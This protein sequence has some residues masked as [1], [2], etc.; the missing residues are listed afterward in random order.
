MSSLAEID[1][2]LPV[3]P[4]CT[5]PG[6][7]ECFCRG[8][9]L[10]L[11]NTGPADLSRE[12]QLVQILEQQ[13]L[14]AAQLLSSDQSL[15]HG[16]LRQ[17]ALFGVD[18]R[19]RAE[20]HA[21][22]LYKYLAGV[23]PNTLLKRAIVR[24]AAAEA[25]LAGLAPF[26]RLL[27]REGYQRRYRRDLL[28]KIDSLFSHA[29]AQRVRALFAV[30]PLSPAQPFPGLVCQRDP[31]TGRASCVQSLDPFMLQRALKP[32][33][34]LWIGSFFLGVSKQ[35]RQELVQQY[36]R[37]YGSLEQAVQRRFRG[38]EREFVLDLI[39]EGRV[40]WGKLLYFCVKGIG[41]DE[42]GLERILSRLSA[43][44]LQQAREEFARVW[45]AHAPWYERPFRFL[46]ADLDRRIWV[47]SGGDAYFELSCYLVEEAPNTPNNSSQHAR[48]ERLYQHE[49][50]GV[51]LKRLEV[52]SRE[53]RLMDADIARIRAFSEQFQP[54]TSLNPALGLRFESMIRYGELDCEIFRSLKHVIGNLATAGTAGACVAGSTW[55]LTS[56]RFELPVVML[57]VGLISCT[58]RIS[59]KSLFKGRGYHR[60][61]L[62]ADLFFG[63]LDG[64]TLF[65]AYFFRQA[66]FRIGT[67]LLTVLGVK[68]GLL[69][70]SR[71]LQVRK[72]RDWPVGLEQ[73][74][75]G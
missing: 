62:S 2:V 54:D 30:D 44:E 33:S 29:R 47:E 49:R 39:H 4:Q 15:Q 10:G 43:E 55:A 32:S 3:L 58:L 36:E 52:F 25:L 7:R 63:A 11:L 5:S 23:F 26:E 6:S 41:T 69:R 34:E 46:L 68:T 14:E 74:G 37:S 53:G 27:L 51:L 56:Q 8:V 57:S 61:E 18:L 66:L 59:L 19:L 71:A 31:D 20:R 22:L 70:L 21:A 12:Q 42:T 64:A 9:A 16:A 72:I 75:A 60:G 48:L 65:A 38:W 73:L 24:A 67:K 28:S 35:Q 1:Q 40:R 45:H 50:S 13:H 17:G